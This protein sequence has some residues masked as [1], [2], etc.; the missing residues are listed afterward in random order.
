MTDYQVLK[1]YKNMHHIWQSVM[2]TCKN[3]REFQFHADFGTVRRF[4][5]FEVCFL[6]CPPKIPGEYA[7]GLDKVY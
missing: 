3:F 5:Q 6:V 4:R 2:W 7:E 1:E